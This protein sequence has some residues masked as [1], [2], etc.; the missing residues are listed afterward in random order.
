VISIQTLEI[1]YG[2]KQKNKLTRRFKMNILEIVI[3]AILV[4]NIVKGIE[5]LIEKD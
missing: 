1:V 5:Y 4:Y 3:L 2:N